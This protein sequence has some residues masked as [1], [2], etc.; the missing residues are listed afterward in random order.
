MPNSI[1]Y[2]SLWLLF[3]ICPVLSIF[4]SISSSW[5]SP[6]YADTHTLTSQ[7]QPYLVSHCKLMSQ[8]DSLL[9]KM[10]C[11]FDPFEKMLHRFLSFKIFTI[12]FCVQD[13]Y[14][15][16]KSRIFQI[17]YWFKEVGLPGKTRKIDSFP[18]S[19]KNCFMVKFLELLLTI[20]FRKCDIQILQNSVTTVHRR[21]KSHINFLPLQIDYRSSFNMKKNISG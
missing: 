18:S 1:T 10:R 16:T 19:E 17:P 7:P 4:N 20:D 9:V 6:D 3:K 11:K 8:P 13:M 5:P 14:Q 15:Y 21:S 2:L 12:C